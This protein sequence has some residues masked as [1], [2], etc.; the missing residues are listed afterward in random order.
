MKLARLRGKRSGFRFCGVGFR[1][2]TK[3]YLQRTWEVP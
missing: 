3:H 1:V 2:S